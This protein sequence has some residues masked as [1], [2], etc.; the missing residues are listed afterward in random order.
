MVISVEIPLDEQGFLDRQC[1]GDTC[2]RYFKVL[3]S[4][5]EASDTTSVTCPFCGYVDEP[6]NFTTEEQQEYLQETALAI[7]HEKLQEMLTGFAKSVNRGQSRNSMFSINV[8]TK[9]SDIPVPVSPD[10]VES[11]RLQ[12][13]CDSCGCTYAVIGSGFFC[14]LCG[15]NSARH[16]FRQSLTKARNAVEVARELGARTDDRDAAAEAKRDALENQINN[17]VTAFQRFGEAIYPELPNYSSAPS[18]N[19]FQRLSQA[20]TKWKE[21]VGRSFEDIVT[22]AEWSE[23]LKYF[24]Q[25]HLLSHQ[26]GFVDADYVAKSGDTAY[27]EGQRLVITESQVLR[28]AELVEKLADGMQSDAPA[29][30]A[31]P[32]PSS[33]KS[34]SAFPPKLP[35][36]TDDDWRVFQVICDVAVEEDG[37]F[38]SGDSVW[39][40]CQQLGITEEQFG[41]S[42]EILESKS[43]VK[44]SQVL[45]SRYIPAGIT[46]TRK[47]LDIFLGHIMPNYAESRKEVAR[48][49][50]EDKSTS[51][52]I[53]EATGLSMLFV[54]HTVKDFESRG[55][56]AKSLWHSGIAVVAVNT[57]VHLKRFISG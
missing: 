35:G 30:N 37:D 44:L 42:L 23:L 36:T 4:D 15:K 29:S 3:H 28:M 5:W 18:R 45:G 40:R 7:A 22:A 50:L 19:L 34:K 1:H 26:D 48:Q 8:Q 53:A 38:L 2:G 6:G 24:Q 14:P 11:M 54:H 47:G 43:L 17:L 9:F 13:K 16:T 21:A 46:V 32:A 10:A 31:L 12:I 41:E 20:S 51:D 33:P 25:R 27:R 39:Q 57:P 56:I 55:W 52:S 49:I